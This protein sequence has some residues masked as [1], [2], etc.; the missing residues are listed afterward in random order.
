MENLNVSTKMINNKRLSKLQR[1]ILAVLAGAHPRGYRRRA[2]SHLVGQ[3]YGNDSLETIEGKRAKIAEVRKQDPARADKMEMF[4]EFFLLTSRRWHFDWQAD[5][6]FKQVGE[7]VNA[8]FAVSLSR[9]LANLRNQHL[10][11]GQA[12][13]FITDKGL[14][15]LSNKKAANGTG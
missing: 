10:I 4:N 7:W 1:I 9:S 6:S 8:G 12:L 15:L 11:T 3:K 5:G 2:L 14:E 13:C